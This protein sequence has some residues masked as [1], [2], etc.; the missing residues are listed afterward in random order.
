MESEAVAGMAAPT[1]VVWTS[2]GTEI[3]HE[4]RAALGKG[5]LKVMQARGVYSALA[6]LCRLDRAAA[7][8][9]RAQCAL[10]LVNPSALD[11][12]AALCG[13]AE[14]Y[15]SRARF[16]MYITG[17][18]RLRA[19][20]SEDIEGWRDGKEPATGKAKAGKAQPYKPQT[21]REEPS[22]TI[23]RPG[24]GVGISR[25][26]AKAGGAVQAA[27]P[28]PKLRLAGDGGEMK[29]EG[30]SPSADAPAAEPG[31]DA[32]KPVIT[33]EELEMLLREDEQ[34]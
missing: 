22:V 29:M 12:P 33:P 34:D 5:G 19:V 16:W 7:V 13:A 23:K 24:G 15:A 8:D 27:E 2:P 14:K 11:S 31:K 10:V 21:P 3:P 18:T 6:A 28:G 32:R 17:A 1:A 26:G 20:T 4:L 25:T 30:G 9:A